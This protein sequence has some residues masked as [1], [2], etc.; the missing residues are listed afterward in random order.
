MRRFMA[1]LVGALCGAL[2]GAITALLLTP[3]SGEVLRLR[4]Q[5][6]LESFRDEIREAY[7]TRVAQLEAELEQLRRG[8][9]VR[10]E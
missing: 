3:V 6:R 10:T 2:V 5:S 9:D 1:F 4:A 7:G 8:R